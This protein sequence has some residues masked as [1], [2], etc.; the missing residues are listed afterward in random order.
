MPAYFGIGSYADNLP[1]RRKSPRVV[2]GLEIREGQII[3]G[4]RIILVEF[5]RL[6]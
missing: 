1:E 5:H 3:V 2:L 6:G 4:I